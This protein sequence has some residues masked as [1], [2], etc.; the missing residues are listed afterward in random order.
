MA[1]PPTTESRDRPVHRRALL[2]LL[3][4]WLLAA[5]GLGFV[6]W[7]LRRAAAA[8][9]ESVPDYLAGALAEV[10]WVPWLV[11]MAGYSL[12]YVLLDAAVVTRV[13]RWSLVPARYGEVLPLRAA[14][15]LLAVLNEPVGKAALALGL[16]RR[17]RV[18]IAAAAS[19]M[20]FLA[21]AEL[22]SLA[23]WAVLGH[24]I[25]GDRL[26][27]VF[28]AVPAVTAGVLVAVVAAHLAVTRTAA[29]RALA[30]RRPALQAFGRATAGRYLEVLGWR[31]PLML[32]A[33]LVYSR[34]LGW[35]GVPVG[36]GE[37]LG[38][39][40]VVLLGVVV[41]GP[42]RA[43]AVALWVLLFPDHPAQAAAF[44]LLQHLAF[45]LF[46]ALLGAAFLTRATRLLADPGPAAGAGSSPA[47]DPSTPAS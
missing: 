24:R 7:R 21:V 30:A 32:L 19:A 36:F 10:A 26:P 9:G 27:A 16:R 34:S 1:A 33:V 31:A 22:V 23:L 12:V 38:I 6:G 43:V 2:P 45:L 15:H 20:V 28:D 5:A 39:L 18:P 42:M 44:G 3:A 46:N 17:Y 40:P 35:F 13:V 41:P 37:M 14:A 4:G 8:R 11:A 25:A 29:G 47:A